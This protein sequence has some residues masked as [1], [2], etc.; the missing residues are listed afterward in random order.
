VLIYDYQKQLTGVL[1]GIDRPDIDFRVNGTF[2]VSNI[3]LNFILIQQVGWR[4]AAIATVL[5]SGISLAY[6]YYAVSKI[7]P[8][9]IPVKE[10]GIQI[11]A[12][13]IMAITVFLL[14]AV[15]TT[16]RVIDHNASIVF[17]LVLIGATIYMGTLIIISD[18]TRQTIFDNLP[19][20]QPRW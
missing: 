20:D 16:H 15:E 18:E 3:I 5:S 12:S 4:G 11:G 10:I 8:V 1:Q 17:G 2:I 7:L 13:I 19:I 14:E 9:N 6:A